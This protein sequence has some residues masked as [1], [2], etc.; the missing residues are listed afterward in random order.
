MICTT[1]K[2]AGRTQARLNAT[3]I[4]WFYGAIV[5]ISQLIFFTAL[6]TMSDWPQR[7]SNVMHS[8]FGHRQEAAEARAVPQ[9]L[10]QQIQK[11]ARTAKERLVDLECGLDS[12]GQPQVHPRFQGNTLQLNDRARGNVGDGRYQLYHLCLVNR[13]KN[14]HETAQVR[15]ELALL[16]GS[17]DL[18]VSF[19]NPRPSLVSFDVASKHP[20]AAKD[21]LLLDSN[22]PDWP[23]TDMVH[24]YI[25]VVGEQGGGSYT[26]QAATTVKAAQ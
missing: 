23:L 25:G 19:S 26:L 6:A 11:V 21:V 20:G 7:V 5:V 13:P 9:H 22:V 10:R 4:K 15:L 17:A 2:P 1:T 12:L 16:Q 24:L 8:S 14:S 3:R 18:L